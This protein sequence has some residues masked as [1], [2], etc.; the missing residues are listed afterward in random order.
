MQNELDARSGARR[1]VE[2]TAF[3]IGEVVGEISRGVAEEDRGAAREERFARETGLRT[4]V[5]EQV[6]RTLFARGF[7][8]ARHV[9]LRERVEL[10]ASHHAKRLL[11]D[12]TAAHVCRPTVAPPFAR[13]TRTTAPPLSRF[14]RTS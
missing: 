6:E 12:D 9:P 2:I 14:A 13:T 1:L 10:R 5:V 11:K 3:T 4:A 7:Q 8:R